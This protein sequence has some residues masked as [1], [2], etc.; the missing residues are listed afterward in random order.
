MGKGLPCEAAEHEPDHGEADE[1]GDGSRVALVV[2]HEAAVAADPC[3]GP[4]DNPTLGKHG[5]LVRLGALD[6][7]DD[8]TARAGGRQCGTRS[9]VA[10]IGKDARDKGPQ[11][12][13]SLV[14]H[15][16]GA[17]TVPRVKPEG[18]L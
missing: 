2:A 10:G 15:E 4:L 6:D 12:A 16:R 3:Q 5:E 11:G 7:L 13:R 1:S 8:P 18:R 17:V 9:P 14:E